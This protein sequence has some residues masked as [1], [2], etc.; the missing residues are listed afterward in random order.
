MPFTYKVDTFIPTVSGCGAKDNGWD[1][2]RCEQ[3]QAFLNQYA[4]SGWRLHS[5]DFREVTVAGC[6]GGK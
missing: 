6:G 5:S 2:K 4:E 1:S 3:F